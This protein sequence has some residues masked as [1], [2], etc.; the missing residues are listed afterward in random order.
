MGTLHNLTLRTAT[1][2]GRLA[3]LQRRAERVTD[4]PSPIAKSALAEL[5]TALEEL[6]V[7]NE[8][9]QSQLDELN[10]TRGNIETVQRANEEFAQALPIAVVWTDRRGLIEKSN[11][12]A[13]QLLNI[14]KHHLPGK[15]LM[16]FIT[17]R[18]LFFAA[19]RSL[20]EADD[21][22]AVDIDITV[23]PRERRPRRMKLCG[24]RLQ[25][26]DARC[27]WFLH[28]GMSAHD[29][30]VSTEPLHHDAHQPPDSEGVV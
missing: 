18:G 20:C 16:L 4:K 5:S 14:G 1:A 13:S 29:R 6:Q 11:D 30:E 2:V 21:V 24:R 28:E 10:A 7:A 26:D 17:D 22:P 9:L 23:R 25:H 19:L 8:A 15:P 27:V 12:A 3:E